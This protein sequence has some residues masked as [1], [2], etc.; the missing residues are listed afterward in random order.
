MKAN[1]RLIGLVLLAVFFFSSVTP[2][3][4]GKVR[5]TVRNN[6][7]DTVYIKL[8]AKKAFY[9]LTVKD[10]YETYTVKPALY[11]A[12]FWGCGSKKVIKKLEINRQL[13]MIF[14]VCNAVQK[15]TEKNVLRIIFNK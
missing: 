1:H 14:P 3:Y 9:Y 7:N 8:E 13:R 2:F 15:P 4:F 5:L 11:K 12:T 10:S 6:T